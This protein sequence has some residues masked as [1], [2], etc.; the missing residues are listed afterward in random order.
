VDDVG[1]RTTCGVVIAVGVASG[2]ASAI[3]A[4]IIIISADKENIN[5]T[6]EGFFAGGRPPFFHN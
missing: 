3:A 1:V 2:A 4:P 5:Q 6:I